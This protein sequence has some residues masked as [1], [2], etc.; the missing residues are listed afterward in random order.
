MQATQTNLQPPTHSG[1]QP[2][3]WPSSP[4][5]SPSPPSIRPPPLL[6]IPPKISPSIDQ[7]ARQ[8]IDDPHPDGDAPH[9]APHTHLGP[10]PLAP[11]QREERVQPAPGRGHAARGRGEAREGE[12]RAQEERGCE[13]EEGEGLAGAG[14]QGYDEGRQEGGGY[15]GCY[16][17]CQFH[18][19]FLFPS[20]H[21]M[22]PS[23]S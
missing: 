23:S 13:E 9:R 1:P 2:V 20:F 10:Q 7:P 18:P 8:T 19:S 15:G 21:F 4:I 12:V 11:A 3:N 16:S 5:K 14:V 22:F 17:P 6:L